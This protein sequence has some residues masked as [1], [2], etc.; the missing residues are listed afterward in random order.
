MENSLSRRKFIKNL[1]IIGGATSLTSSIIPISAYAETAFPATPDKGD[2]QDMFL[3]LN[4][5][6]KHLAYFDPAEE[7]VTN[8]G[9][10]VTGYVVSDHMHFA[11][12]SSRKWKE[13]E[14]DVPMKLDRNTFDEFIQL[15]HIDN[16]YF[17]ADWR[18]F[19]K[20][21][22]KLTLPEEWHWMMEAVEKH[23]KPWSFRVMNCSPHSPYENSLPDFLQGKFKMTP[24]WQK[25][26]PAP[27]P[28][29][30]P[31]YNEEYLKWWG[32]L[33]ELT[34]N[35]FDNHPLLE[36]TDIAGF[37]FWGEMHHWAEYSPNGKRENYYP[38]SQDVLDK[39]LDSIIKSY[40]DAF[41]K[42]PIAL[43]LAARDF[44]P[45][46]EAYKQGL[47]W[48]RRDSFQTSYSLS[49]LMLSQGLTKGVG[50]IWEI[51]I[52]GA[53][54]QTDEQK[55]TDL[56]TKALPQ[57]YFDIGSHYVAMG[58]NPWEAIY[59]H[60][61][62]LSTCQDVHR[63]IGYK[64]RP[65]IIWKRKNSSND[66][67]ELILGLCNDGCVG[68]PGQLTVHCKFS[69]GQVVSLDL[70][71]G[72]PESRNIKPFFLP[73]PKTISAQKKSDGCELTLSLKMKGKVFPVKWA[74][75]KKQVK[76]PYKIE[77]SWIS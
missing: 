2:L 11:G 24:Y 41:P 70:P 17:R 52:P 18:T 74:V 1:A 30:F 53:S 64:V 8:P 22:G 55:R 72:E 45:G 16:L 56:M 46:I 37:G 15:P 69:N 66:S 51:I 34:G 42:T 43:C 3:K 77:V 20:E 28:K 6:G 29:Y 33:V 5:S 58:F 47:V 57:R 14:G 36:Y 39:C 54:I 27:Y 59:A 48:P 19:Q 21:K 38:G 61:N 40:L 50:M 13:T 12:D 10:G 60:K 63:Q 49:E 44:K 67:E 68:I 26:L 73:I 35:Q 4:D 32:E 75:S 9:M 25:G 71:L 7:T 62:C 31:E 65:S 23:N 76:D